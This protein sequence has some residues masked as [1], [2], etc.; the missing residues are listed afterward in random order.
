[1]ISQPARR[2]R[3]KVLTDRMVASFPKKRKRYPV[4]DPEL[5]GHYVRVMPQ[6]ANVFVAVARDP[7]GK[8]VWTTIGS[9]DKLSIAK[10]RDEARKRINH[11]AAGLPAG[12]AAQ[13]EAGCVPERGGELVEAARHRQETAHPR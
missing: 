13:A 10:A 11:I 2:Q 5:R 3:R 12:R 8:Q 6:G 7:Y 9:A 1:M 4:P